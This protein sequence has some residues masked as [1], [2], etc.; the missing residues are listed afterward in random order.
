MTISDN[1]MKY[2]TDCTN[3]KLIHL[4]LRKVRE[5]GAITY[6]KGKYKKQRYR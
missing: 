3:L 5:L 1:I 2:M 4:Y 6:K